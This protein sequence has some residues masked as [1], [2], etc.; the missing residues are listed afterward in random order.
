MRVHA[1][2]GVR[3]HACVCACARVSIWEPTP[4]PAYARVYI[5]HHVNLA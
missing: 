3:V 1:C 4:A 2:A 5:N